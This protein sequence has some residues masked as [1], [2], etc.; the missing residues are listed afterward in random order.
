MIE[1]SNYN[2][3][4]EWIKLFMNIEKTVTFLLLIKKNI[5]VLINQTGRR[6][7][8]TLEFLLLKS[9]EVFSLK[10]TLKL[11]EGK[12]LLGVNAVLINWRRITLELN[13]VQRHIGKTKKLL[14]S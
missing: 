6:R 14:R 4:D 11:E 8:E 2:F 12:K 13:F 9:M 5:D 7:K 1:L 3:L 10:R